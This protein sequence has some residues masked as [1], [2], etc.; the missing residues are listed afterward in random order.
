MTAVTRDR[1]PLPGIADQTPEQLGGPQSLLVRQ[2]RDHA[3]LDDLLDAVARARG[4]AQDEALTRL[5]RLVFP[6]AYAEETVLWPVLRAAFPDGAELTLRN[7]REHQEINEVFRALDRV[8]A[9]APDRAALLARLTALLRSDVRD[10]EDLL[11]PRLQAA[12]TVPQLRWLGVTWELVRCTAPT[13][14]HAV[15]S[16]RPPGNLL[17]AAPLSALDR[18]RDGLDRSARRWPVLAGPFT[19]ASRALGLLAGAVE[20]VPPLGRGEHPATRARKSEAPS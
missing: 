8:P 1:A 12:L 9:G 5:A 20:H 10:E 19:T 4:S 2:R 17:S 15:V 3:R 16:R 13:R 18:T 7:E 11:L 6:H 14:P